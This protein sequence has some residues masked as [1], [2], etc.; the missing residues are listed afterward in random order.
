MFVLDHSPIHKFMA[1]DALNASAM[2]VNPGG[3][4]P[5][6]RDGYFY[7]YNITCPQQFLL[8]HSNRIIL[9]NRTNADGNVEKIQQKMVDANGVARGLRAICA[10]RFGQE[11]IKGK[12]KGDL[13]AM[14]EVEEDF[15]NQRCLLEEV[16][17]QEGG[18]LS[19]LPKFT[20]E[21][22]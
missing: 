12:I 18:I 20:P 15:A 22:R 14:L 2:N 1:K 16:V 17:E 7:R 8:K 11:A 10:E 21:L 3:A 13:I 9:L 19:F 6:M 5:K 4:Q